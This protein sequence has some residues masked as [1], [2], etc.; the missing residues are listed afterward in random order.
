MPN[1]AFFVQCSADNNVAGFTLDGRQTNNTVRNI[2]EAP[3]M[4]RGTTSERSVLNLYLENNSFVDHTRLVVNE[5]ASMEYEI[6]CD[7]SKFMSDDNTVPQLFT[8][9]NNE[10]MAI[11]E[12][13]L[14][15]GKAALG[16]YIGVAGTHTFSL[17]TKSN[18]T[19]V[20]LIDKVTGVETDLTI[21]SYT[22]SAE[23]G[24]YT[25]RFEIR[26]KRTGETSITEATATEVKVAAESGAITIVNATET[27]YV[28]N[29]AGALVATV[30][31]KAA[32][33]EVAPGIYVV[34]V[35]E[36]AH[37]VSVVK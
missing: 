30:N 12:R 6:S 11:N 22:F 8:I 31:E 3:S 34:K 28:Y 37:K 26:M 5:K 9:E 10:R 23:A 35:G 25:D 14:A 24:T 19:E 16:V 2:T 7:A 20:V 21:D 17:D 33:I 18:D 13:P 27:I 15:D 1:E 4:G 29:A 32:T 36:K